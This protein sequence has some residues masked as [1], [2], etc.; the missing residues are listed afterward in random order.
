MVN[1]YKLDKKQ[2]KIKQLL[3][4]YNSTQYL[5]KNLT[6]DEPQTIKSI[7][8]RLLFLNNEINRLAY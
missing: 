4:E 1:K 8:N 3:E 5:L 7:G 2:L 6:R